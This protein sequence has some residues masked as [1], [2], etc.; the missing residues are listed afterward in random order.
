MSRLVTARRCHLEPACRTEMFISTASNQ[1][2]ICLF[3]YLFLV[4][5]YQQLL[6]SSFFAV[7]VPW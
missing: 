1:R 4:V 6:F 3:I 5:L 2:I 7:Q